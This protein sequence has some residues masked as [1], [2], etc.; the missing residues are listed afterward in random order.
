MAQALI[1]LKLPP[2][3]ITNKQRTATLQAKNLLKDNQAAYQALV[4]ALESRATVGECCA[5]IGQAT[6]V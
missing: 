2:S 3:S 4:S 6:V 5:A 1:E